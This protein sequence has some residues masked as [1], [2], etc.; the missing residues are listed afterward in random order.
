MWC[1]GG[2]SPAAKVV[3]IYVVEVA[4]ASAAE[5]R[6]LAL[7]RWRQQAQQRCRRLVCTK[8]AAKT[9][10]TWLY[11]RSEKYKFEQNKNYHVYMYMYCNP[12]FGKKY[13]VTDRL[14]MCIGWYCF[15]S[16]RKNHYTL[17]YF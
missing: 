14:Y 15:I 9:D 8:M 16:F 13:Y 1:R 12:T 17:S 10:T 7:Q 5:V 2:S 3:A 11:E 6:Q 4:A